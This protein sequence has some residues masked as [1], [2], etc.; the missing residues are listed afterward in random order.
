VNAL[1]STLDTGL[2]GIGVSLSNA[3]AATQRSFADLQGQID[4]LW[5]AIP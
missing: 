4:S 2:K 5:N 3:A 1:A